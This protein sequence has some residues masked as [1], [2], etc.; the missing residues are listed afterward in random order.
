VVL[1]RQLWRLRARLLGTE[2]V[3]T[4]GD[5][6]AVRESSTLGV[7]G[8]ARL[9]AL[10]LRELAFGPPSRARVRIGDAL[11]EI[12]SDGDFAI[13]W[14]AFV[15]VVGEQPYRGAYEGAAVLDVGAHKGYFGAY[16][17]ARGASVV[18]SFEPALGNFSA[19]ERTAGPLGTRWVARN[20]ALGRSE[21]EGVLRLDRTSWAHSLV[22]VERPAGEQPVSVVTLAQALAELPRNAPRTIVKID[23]EG[24]ECDIL[25]HADALDGVDLLLLEFHPSIAPCTAAELTRSIESKGLGAVTPGNGVMRFRRDPGPAAAGTDV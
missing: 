24:A 17:L 7:R 14:K 4:R 9:Q 6:S 3:V 25:S 22:E 5:L 10:L 1:G 21:G 18:A 19:L 11:V 16:A 8:R 23:A 2:R 13:D 15:E 12:G 20:R